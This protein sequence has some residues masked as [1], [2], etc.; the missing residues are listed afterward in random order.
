MTSCPC[1]LLCLAHS[2]G[3]RYRKALHVHA[4]YFK[5]CNDLDVPVSMDRLRGAHHATDRDVRKAKS[6]QYSGSGPNRRGLK[7]LYDKL[8]K[9]S[10]EGLRYFVEDILP[11]LEKTEVLQFTLRHCPGPGSCLLE[12]DQGHQ[13]SLDTETIISAPV[14]IFN[15]SWLCA[16]QYHMQR[17]TIDMCDCC[18]RCFCKGA[19][20]R[21]LRSPGKRQHH[22]L[23]C[24]YIT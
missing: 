13:P 24:T 18:V 21:I 12:P 11:E 15:S 3:A 6:T 22:T 4:P 14:S 19:P 8:S 2:L 23:I 20:L 1:F 16:C 5:S 10:G 7:I 9:V 17:L